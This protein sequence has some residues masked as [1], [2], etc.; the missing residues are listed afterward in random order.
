VNETAPVTE[1][2]L[3]APLRDYFAGLAMQSLLV[4]CQTFL[5]QDGCGVRMGLDINPHDLAS[6]AYQAADAMLLARKKS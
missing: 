5:K 1:S 2:I 3:T 4:Q 6:N